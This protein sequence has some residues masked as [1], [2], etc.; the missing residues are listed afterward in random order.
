MSY[1]QVNYILPPQLE[2]GFDGSLTLLEILLQIPTDESSQIG[3]HFTFR[4][5]PWQGKEDELACH[6]DGVEAAGYR[7]D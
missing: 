6:A 3:Q 7:D 5:D 1:R 4:F 2:V